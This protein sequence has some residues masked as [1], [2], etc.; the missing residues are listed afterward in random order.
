MP[1]PRSEIENKATG[2]DKILLVNPASE[3]VSPRIS[4]YPSAR[5][6]IT[7]PRS[8]FQLC[9][10]NPSAHQKNDRTKP[11]Y[12]LDISSAISTSKSTHPYQ[13]GRTSITG[14][15][16]KLRK[17]MKTGRLI[18]VACL[19][20]FSFFSLLHWRREGAP[21]IYGIAMASAYAAIKTN[22]MLNA[23]VTIRK[24]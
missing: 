22:D 2:E 4:A 17:I 14:L 8:S 5:N 19:G 21:G 20:L 16:L 23:V 6:R 10:L 12:P 13:R 1:S 24:L 9:C 18:G 7:P 11:L 3:Q 15:R